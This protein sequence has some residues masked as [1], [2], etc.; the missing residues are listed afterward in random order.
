M[1]KSVWSQKSALIGQLLSS[2]HRKFPL[3]DSRAAAKRSLTSTIKSRMSLKPRSRVA[4]AGD[5]LQTSPLRISIPNSER[6][7]SP[8]PSHVGSEDGAI[9]ATSSLPVRPTLVVTGR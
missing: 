1:I 8:V 7:I 6:S 4:S 5:E 2:A 3:A 9:V